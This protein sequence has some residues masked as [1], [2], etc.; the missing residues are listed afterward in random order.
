[1]IEQRNRYANEDVG[2][3]MEFSWERSARMFDYYAAKREKKV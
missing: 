3:Y 2:K 1:M